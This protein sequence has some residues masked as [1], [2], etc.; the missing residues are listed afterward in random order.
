MTE[1]TYAASFDRNGAC[2]R[3][4]TRSYSDNC[5]E[6]AD[7]AD[8]GRAVRDSK[9]PDGP[10]LFFTPDEWTAF[11]GGAKDGEFDD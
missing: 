7:L 11:V 3:R 2:W 8:G 6:V 4:S 10:V 9:D 5:V 1:K